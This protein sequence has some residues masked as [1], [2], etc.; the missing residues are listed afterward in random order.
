MNLQILSPWQWKN[1]RNKSKAIN[2]KTENQSYSF[3]CIMG[4]FDLTEYNKVTNRIG[5]IPDSDIYDND[6][7]EY[8]REIEPHVTILFGLHDDEI[9]EEE[10][11]L[12]L[13]SLKLP[14]VQLTKISS[15]DNEKFDVLKW[16]VES[17]YLNLYNKIVTVM[18]PFT[19]KFPDYHAHCTIAYLQ[20][21]TAK[22]HSKD[23]EEIIELPI[24]KWVYSKADGKKLSVD[25]K[26]EV[27]I[28]REANKSTDE[29][30]THG[31]YLA[32]IKPIS[33]FNGMYS[34]RVFKNGEYKMGVKGPS[35]LENARLAAWR[36]IKPEM[37]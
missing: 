6:E 37:F 18:F 17:E 24:L 3:G 32:E 10:V 11:I 15:F 12:L 22:K 9:D 13:K 31:E 26:G 25:S 19:S 35:T 4:Y 36:F 5:Q 8:G 7:Q 20:P 30:F 33:K 14:T 21:G 1:Q 16:D 34:C 29:S 2:E 27:S 23:I 28:I